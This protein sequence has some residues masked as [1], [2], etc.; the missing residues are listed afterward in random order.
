MMNKLNKLYF[1]L[2]I[3]LKNNPLKFYIL[4]LIITLVF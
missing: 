3:K 2:E 1:D 4:L